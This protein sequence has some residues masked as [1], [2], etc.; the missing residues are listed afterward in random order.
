MKLS[1]TSCLVQ[2]TRVFGFFLIF[3]HDH[4]R[5][6]LIFYYDDLF[7]SRREVSVTAFADD[8]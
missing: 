7:Y 8:I 3:F 2:C 5:I 4:A 6:Y 1:K